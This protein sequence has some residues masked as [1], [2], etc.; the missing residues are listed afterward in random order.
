MN[1]TIPFAG[2]SQNYTSEEI[3]EV[4]NVMQSAE[5]L[6][7]GKYLESFQTKF[8]NYANANHAFAVNNG[9]S[10]IELSAQLCQFNSGDEVI[11]PS[12]TYT[13]S[14]YP[15]LKKGAK[16]VWA[17][18]DLKTRVVTAETLEKCITPNTKAI[19]V[20]HLYGFCADMP[21]IVLMAKRHNLLIIED[22]AQA[23]GSRI[24]N[25]MAGTYGD[26]GIVSFHSHKN[27]T[28][29]GEG[30]MLI[31]KNKKL[32][33]I[34]PMLRHNGHCEFNFERENYWT[35]AMSNVDL[36]ELNDEVIWPNNYCLGEVECA[37]G[38]KLLDRIDK[39]NEEKKKR[40]IYFIDEIS[41]YD[42][43]YFHRED[44][45]RH[46]YH[47]L[48]GQVLHGNRDILIQK[49][50]EAGVQCVVQ[51][52]PLNRYDLYKRSGF[53]YADCPNADTFF[54]NMISFPFQYMMSEDTFMRLV[55]ITKNVLNS[56]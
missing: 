2:R 8:C 19:V 44:S 24:D 28:T 14:A 36:A 29:L 40:A 37:L 41:G 34:I 1:F 9:T 48:V 30:G 32:A 53:G 23:L 3:N 43:L 38:I 54:D 15:F 42:Q 17:D 11:I 47:L 13:A 46:N 7:Q 22:A 55:K 35:P 16:I 26:L 45:L 21:K 25:Q 10:A 39:I 18:I 52:Y 27:I 4:I 6:T 31:V 12:H 51:Y 49:M 33:S 20:V 5:T 50:A 56:M